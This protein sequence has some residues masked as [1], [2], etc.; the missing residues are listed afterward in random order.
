MSYWSDLNFWLIEKYK[1]VR[2]KIRYWWSPSYRGKHYGEIECKNF[3][4]GI[5]EAGKV[6]EITNLIKMEIDGKNHGR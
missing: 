2:H 3:V 6:S 1:R 5:K 4:L